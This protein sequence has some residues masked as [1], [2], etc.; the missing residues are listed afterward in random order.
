MQD[1]T[2]Q[3]MVLNL[4]NEREALRARGLGI[5]DV[6]NAVVAAA[7]AER[8]SGDPLWLLLVSGSGNAKT[9]T[10]QAL[11]GIGAIIT[12]TITSDRVA[13]VAAITWLSL[14][15]GV[16]PAGEVSRDLSMPL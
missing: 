9:E 2:V 6:V 16:M 5:L 10:V 7:A 3:R 12:S 4:L 11:S 14:R 1:V 8:L 13:P 15:N